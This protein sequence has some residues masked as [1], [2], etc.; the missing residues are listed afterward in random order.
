MGYNRKQ[1]KIAPTC[2]VIGEKDPKRAS[3]TPCNYQIDGYFHESQDTFNTILSKVLKLNQNNIDQ[4]SYKKITSAIRY[5]R[6]GSESPELE[7][8]LLNYWIGLEFIFTSFNSEEKTIDR[9]RK[10]FPISHN[11][12]YVKRNLIDLHKTIK[13]LELSQ[14]IDNYNDDLRYLLSNQTYTII[15]SKSESELLTYRIA[16]MQKWYQEPNKV[17]D[18]LRKHTDN[19]IWN[20]T[21]LYRI[22]NEI[23]HNAAIKN[24]IY[25]NIAHLKYYLSFI[26]NSIIDF[27]SE[28]QVQTGDHNLTIDDYFT[29]QEVLYSCLNKQKLEKYLEV[30][31]PP[32][33]LQQSTI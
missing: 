1:Y 17:Q 24:G 29:T 30:N 3:V 13:R 27:M 4:D 16:Y 25:T 32:S 12:I 26:L 6:T 8:K 15:T 21:R 31:I 22:R 11:L 28:D 14:Y 18:L 23:V 10:Y 7:T 9:I 5:Y 19:L 20:I 2:L 33:Y